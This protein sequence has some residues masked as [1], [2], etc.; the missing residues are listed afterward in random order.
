MSMNKSGVKDEA[1]LSI[2]GWVLGFLVSY[3][4]FSTVLHFVFF[5]QEIYVLS[6]LIV[7]VIFCVGS[8][9][10]WWLR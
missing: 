4:I 3:F 2:I 7:A 1:A 5:R 8:V 10:K 6:M 9:L